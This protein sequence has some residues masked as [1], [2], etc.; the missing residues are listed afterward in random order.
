[1]QSLFML[2]DLV[3]DLY[4]WVLI[5]WVVLSWLIA[6]NVVNTRS[7]AVHALGNFLYRTTEPV[8]RQV[9]SW[10]PEFGGIDISPIVILLAIFFLRN[11]LRE[12]WPHG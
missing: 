5:A 4:S 7:P 1:M 12:Y 8:L 9:R 2:I 3:L 11:L 6:F 10:L